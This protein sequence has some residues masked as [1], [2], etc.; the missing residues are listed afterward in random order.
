MGRLPSGP[1]RPSARGTSATSTFTTSTLTAGSHS[2]SVVYTATG[3]FLDST[4]SISTQTVDQA[5]L[6]ITADDQSKVYGA[7][8]PTLTASYSGFV[9]GDTP[10]SLDDPAD[11]H[12]SAT[13]AS[14]VAGRPYAIIAGGA[15]GSNYSISYVDG[16]LTVTPASLDDRRR[17]IQV[18]RSAPCRR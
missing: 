13:S 2:I 8:L 15:A 16:S 5:I 18:L 1:A 3:S 7:A 4:S 10:A 14:H 17:S 12:T 11:A 6:T 9:N